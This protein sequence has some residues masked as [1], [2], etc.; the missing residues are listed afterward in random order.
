M[1]F[2]WNTTHLFIK[3]CLWLLSVQGQSGGFR[4]EA[5][6]TPQSQKKLQSTFLQKKFSAYMV[7]YQKMIDTC[8]FPLPVFKMRWWISGKTAER[9]T[10]CSK[11]IWGSP[12]TKALSPY[13]RVETSVKFY[14]TRMWLP[15]GRRWGDLIGFPAVDSLLDP[16]QR[17]KANDFKRPI[18]KSYG[19][20]ARLTL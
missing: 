16:K 12:L 19:I 15:S 6:Y 13:F 8:N 11:A 14:K 20:A 1:K 17:R 5:L 3:Y 10:L 18:T 9:R 4:A 2:Y 7:F